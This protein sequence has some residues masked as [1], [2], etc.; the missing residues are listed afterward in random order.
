M[1]TVYAQLNHP[2]AV[3]MYK[4]LY[5]FDDSR[6]G[7][8]AE[9]LMNEATRVI[10]EACQYAFNRIPSEVKID[11]TD[12]SNTAE[13]IW[14][15]ESDLIFELDYIKPEGS[16]SIYGAMAISPPEVADEQA[17]LFIVSEAALEAS[18]VWLCPVLL[19]YFS[20]PPKT[21]YVRIAPAK[22]RN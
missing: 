14:N 12:N 9:P 3:G 6:K 21:L 16:G 13:N 2:K 7:I 8:T 10:Q 20:S 19:D 18:K 17:A 15:N 11:F 1:H 4:Q 22:P 5:C